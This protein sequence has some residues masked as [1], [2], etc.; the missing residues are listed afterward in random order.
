MRRVRRRHFSLVTRD[1]SWMTWYRRRGEHGGRGGACSR[2][3]PRPGLGGSP[4]GILIFWLV[5]FVL[6]FACFF[7]C[8]LV[9]VPGFGGHADL[10]TNRTTARQ[11]PNA[12]P[13]PRQRP[14]PLHRPPRHITRHRAIKNT[15]ACSRV[16]VVVSL[17]IEHGT[18]KPHSRAVAHPKTHKSGAW[19][20]LVHVRA[21]YCVL[22]FLVLLGPKKTRVVHKINLANDDG[23]AGP[24]YWHGAGV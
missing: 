1:G 11:Q 15:P 13:R 23:V 6:L 7:L 14:R 24:S 18:L 9:L 3:S 4:R 5:L 2:R 12:P 22:A 19:T 10:G 8:L 20:S 16:L 21:R 17:G